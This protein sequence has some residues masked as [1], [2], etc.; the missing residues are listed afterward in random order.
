MGGSPRK[1]TI[2]QTAPLA[3]D[4][5]T[6]GLWE[7]GGVLFISTLSKTNL[8]PKTL[9]CCPCCCSTDGERENVRSEIGL[10][11]GGLKPLN[12]TGT[13]NYEIEYI[14]EGD[15]AAV[16]SASAQLAEEELGAERQV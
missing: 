12:N 7:N 2:R 5:I 11:N 10:S 4:T 16:E 14:E 13:G 15:W 3:A 8:L 9:S 6:E 1:S